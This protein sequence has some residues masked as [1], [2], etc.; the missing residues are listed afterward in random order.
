MAAG[1]AQ[2][3]ERS[4]HPPTLGLLGAPGSGKSAAAAHLGGR[5]FCVIDADRLAREALRHPSVVGA[6]GARFEASHPGIIGS[7]GQVDRGVL[8]EVVFVEPEVRRWLE[9]LIHPRVAAERQRIRATVDPERYPAGVVEDCPL[10]LETGLDAVCDA[11]MMIDADQAARV[12]RVRERGWDAAELARR[13]AAQWPL[14]RKRD[15]AGVVIDNSGDL[16][17]L[18]RAIDAWLDA[19]WRP[20]RPS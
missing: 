3:P 14:E 11:L 2:A 6:I 18:G 16:A 17:A 8:A 15:A 1:D 12:A 10:L 13:D 7:D 5:G 4:T 19:H 20:G 9:G